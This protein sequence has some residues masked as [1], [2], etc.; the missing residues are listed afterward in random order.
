MKANTNK[1]SLQVMLFPERTPVYRVQAELR[2][3]MNLEMSVIIN[4]A[5]IYITIT[6]KFLI[7]CVS[8]IINRVEGFPLARV[9]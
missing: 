6:S 8:A 7:K 5:V 4:V 2:S 3:G 9:F 1:D